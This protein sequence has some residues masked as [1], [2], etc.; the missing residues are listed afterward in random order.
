MG[1]VS[2]YQSTWTLIYPTGMT[3]SQPSSDAY[4]RFKIAST[5][6]DFVTYNVV[7][8]IA[9]VDYQTD[10]LVITTNVIFTPGEQFFI[11]LDPGVFLSIATCLRDS[12]GITDASF[13]LFE[14]ASEPSTTL[15]I[16][17]TTQL[18]TITTIILNRTVSKS[19]LLI[20]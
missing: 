19:C 13:W 10:R 20:Y 16:T 17:T 9:S 11:S 2:K 6:L 1:L 15:I 4:I 18:I 8:Q 7:K 14:I 5:Q 3:F 12:M